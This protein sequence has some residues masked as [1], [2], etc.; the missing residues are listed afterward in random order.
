M[1]NRE[2]FACW[3]Q[4]TETIV[5]RKVEPTSLQVMAL[6]FAEKAVNLVDANERLLD[7]TSGTYGYKDNDH[8]NPDG[9]HHSHGH[10]NRSG[11]VRGGN[12]H[13]GG[14]NRAV[15]QVDTVAMVEIAEIEQSV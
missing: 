8:Y 10:H 11:G 13:R 3:D 6:Q 7:T 1:G 2:L 14:G 5:L 15:I 12:K 9:R 4:P